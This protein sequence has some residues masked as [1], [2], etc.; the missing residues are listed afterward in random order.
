MM[1]KP[2]GQSTFENQLTELT[3]LLLEARFRVGGD[4]AEYCGRL[5]AE[6]L[7]HCWTA[8]VIVMFRNDNKW[9]Q[10]NGE[11]R[12]HVRQSWTLVIQVDGEREMAAYVQILQLR[13]VIVGGIRIVLDGSIVMQ[14][15]VWLPIH[16]WL[17]DLI[18]CAQ[19]GGREGR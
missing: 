10:S 17:L 8:L 1:T 11:I 14:T 13:V 19:A 12:I 15:R 9:C 4:G 3:W 6:L 5:V 16:I 2:V 18:A 7:G